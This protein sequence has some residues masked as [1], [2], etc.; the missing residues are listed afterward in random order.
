MFITST[1]KYSP[2]RSCPSAWICQRRIRASVDELAQQV[3]RPVRLAAEQLR[4]GGDLV[5]AVDQVGDQPAADAFD[6]AALAPGRNDFAEVERLSRA[7]RLR[8]AF[9]QLAR[10]A[11]QADRLRDVVRRADG[12]HR[13]RAPELGR[14][15]R[16]PAHRAVAAGGHD[17]VRGLLQERLPVRFRRAVA[18]LVAGLGDQLDEPARVLAGA[19]ARV[20]N[21]GNLHRHENPRRQRRRRPQPRHRGACARSIAVR[22]RAR[23]RAGRRTVVSQSRN[24]RFTSSDIPPGVPHPRH[25]GVAGQRH[26]RGLHRPRRAQ[27]GPRGHRPVGHQPGRQSGQRDLAFR[28]RSRPPSR[29]RCSGSAASRSARRRRARTGR[30]PTTRRSRRTSSAC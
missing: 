20:V 27:L 10:I 28:A 5:L 17:E 12:N 21:Q 2:E 15:Q 22:R 11:E 30:S 7:R 4:I 9:D 24:H 3:Q 8:P 6:E 18:H 13:E 25:R 23:R 29:R 14:G 1:A 16:D 19:C 26:A